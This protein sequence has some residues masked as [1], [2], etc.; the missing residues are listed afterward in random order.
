[1]PSAPPPAPGPRERLLAAA[2]EAF[3]E[4]GY[5][6]SIDHIAARA[7]VARQTLYNYFHSKDE[8]FGE[9]V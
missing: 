2:C 4:E 5:Q 1:M 8:L 9:A 3:C 6:V 7:Q